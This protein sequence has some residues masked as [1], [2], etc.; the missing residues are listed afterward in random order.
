MIEVVSSV[1][2]ES[3]APA[4]TEVEE[5]EVGARQGTEK[6]PWVAEPALEIPA[7]T[8]II[9]EQPSIQSFSAPKG[10]FFEPPP[11]EHPILTSYYKFSHELIAL[12]RESSFQ[13]R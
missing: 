10:E 13:V 1:P 3:P 9:L 11:S 4:T 7:F 8:P 5:G 2:T 6:D 12:V